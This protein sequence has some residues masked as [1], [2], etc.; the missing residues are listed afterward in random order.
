MIEEYVPTKISPNEVVSFVREKDYKFIHELGEGAC[1]VTVLLEDEYLDQMYVCKK[2]QPI[3][4]V[5]RQELYEKFVSE[6]KILHLL[7]HQN[8][9]RI[10]NSYLYPK[11]YTG[12][13]LM[14][15]VKGVD[16]DKFLK[17]SPEQINEV[18]IQTIAGFSYLEKSGIL[19][20]D[21][22]TTNILVDD[23]GNVK[24]ID[25]GFGKR[26]TGPDD[27][28]KSI[29][30]NWEFEPPT[31]FQIETYDYQTEVYFVGKLFESI[32]ISNKNESF[33]YPELLTSMCRPAREQRIKGFSDV[34]QALLNDRFYEIGFNELDKK[35]YRA[36]ADALR[37]QIHHF[38]TGTKYYDD[39]QAIQKELENI[40]RAVMLEVAI[41][42]CRAIIRCLVNGGFSFIKGGFPVLTLRDFVQLLKKSTVEQKKLIMLNLHTRLDAILR[43]DINDDLP[44]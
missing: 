39:I 11:T 7:A 5:Q 10:Y 37:K 9:V 23:M 2:F 44:F 25:F 26:I 40:Y 16:I 31:D 1:G 13:I 12:Y 38:T 15:Y 33:K 35:I 20:R 43:K 17:E 30:L 18:F 42:D 29:S 24:I 22:R 41:P 6:V 36:F 21:V 8:I 3:Y 19:H 27:F 4:E 28:S 14:E 32:I 34:D